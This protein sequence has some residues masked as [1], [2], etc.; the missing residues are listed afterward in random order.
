M[1]QRHN[2]LEYHKLTFKELEQRRID[3]PYHP[4]DFYAHN[5]RLLGDDV[6]VAAINDY[7][8]QS[9]WAHH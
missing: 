3:S 8:L 1:R 6:S 5:L 2:N 9:A 7:C 4:A